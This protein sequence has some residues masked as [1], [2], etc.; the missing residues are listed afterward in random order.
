MRL[1]TSLRRASSPAPVDDQQIARLFHTHSPL[2]YR[3]ALRLLKNPA[4]AQEATQEVFIRLLQHLSRLDSE[5]DLLPW[6]FRTTTNYCLNLLRDRG[7][8]AALLE[9]H[10]APRAAG[11]QPRQHDLVALRWLLA[12]ADTEQARAA[13][14][15]YL[16]GFTYDEAAEVMAV[17]RRTIANLLVRFR[18]W[19]L[20]ELEE[21]AA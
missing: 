21:T 10:Q 16:D 13:V 11:Q 17:S 5:R 12:E 6:L 19:A 18:R 2:V 8:R 9:A 4:D 14:Y 1:R 15:V 7:R 20:R 3:R